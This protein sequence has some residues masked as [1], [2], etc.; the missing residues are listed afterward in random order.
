MA[1]VL[2]AVHD[3]DRLEALR[4]TALLDSPPEPAFDR[5]TRLASTMLRA[6]VALVSLVDQDRQFFKAELGLPEPW[7][8]QRQTPLSH[9][10]CRHVV[11]DGAP[12][13][14]ADARLDPVLRENRAVAELGIVAYLGVPLTTTEGHHLGALCV[15]DGTPRSWSRGEVL[16]L[17]D[18]A[19]SAMT[20]IEL[21]VELMCRQHSA[22]ALRRSEGLKAAIL[23]SALDGIVVIDQAGSVVE[24]N[25]AAERIFGYRRGEVLGR[26][27]AELI[28]PPESRVACSLG[29]ALGVADDGR[30]A[31]GRMIEVRAMRNGGATF[32]AEVAIAPIPSDGPPLYTAYVRDLTERRRAEEE[33]RVRERQ[34]RLLAENSIDLISRHDPEGRYAYASPACREL[35]GYEPEELVGVLAYDLIHPGDHASVRKVHAALLAGPDP[36]TIAFRARRKDGFYRWVESTSRAV[37]DPL[38]GAVQELQSTWR[39]V[40]ERIRAAKD[41]G[42][43]NAR[44]ERRLRW[45]SA[46]R[47]IDAAI[48]SGRDLGEV[49]SL[50]TEQAVTQLGVDSACLFLHDEAD[51]TLIRYAEAGIPSARVAWMPVEGSL[52]GRVVRDGCTIHLAD[53]GRIAGASPGDST[54]P[55]GHPTAYHVVPMKADGR[56]LGVLELTQFAPLHPD[57]E[58][59][60]FAEALASQAAVIVENAD[61]QAA[62][63]RAHAD[64]ASAYEDTLAGWARALDLRDRETEGHS[65][66]VTEMTVRVAGLMGLGEPALVHVRRGALLHD[67]GK[68]GI[69]DAI[70]LKPGPLTEEEWRVMRRHP[71]LACEMLRPI[72]FLRPALEIPLCHH[73]KWDGTGYPRGLKGEEIPLAARIF[74]AVD[75]SDA[76]LNDRPYRKAWAPARVREHIAGLA[77]NHLDPRVVEVFLALGEADPAARPEGPPEAVPFEPP[78]D[79]G[80]VAAVA[81]LTA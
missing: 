44:L 57:A 8:S 81:G 37:L 66:R 30:P 53:P 9:S 77:G 54:F 46:M 69:P 42:R 25:P 7:S 67:I 23:E 47:K 52:P 43:L 63:Q 75:I 33:V 17:Q 19:A 79:R 35:L 68:M 50:V 2:T 62:H 36:R 29:L 71:D 80:L 48:T 16:L 28:V 59:L 76:L 20:E 41:I 49:L 78:P 4:R 3:P 24:W 34:F 31:S 65:R 1:D 5:L 13:V 40:T 18:L 73:E 51:A 38:T 58:W 21:R 56:I 11:A 45:I 14:V 39:D 27:M 74:A 64:L 6:P 70:L 61:L 55:S 32:P 15:I 10:F 26:P 12:L 22:E 72:E 60:E